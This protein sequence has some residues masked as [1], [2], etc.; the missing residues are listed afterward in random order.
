MSEDII[1]VLSCNPVINHICPD[2]SSIITYFNKFVKNV[3]RVEKSIHLYCTHGN[4]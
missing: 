4:V 2:P 3:V 1:S